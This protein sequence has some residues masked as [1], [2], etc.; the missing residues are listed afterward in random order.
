[1][2]NT[3]HQEKHFEDYIVSK[4]KAQGWLVGTTSGY[5]TERALYADDLIGWLQDTQPEK[6]DKLVQG[7]G[8]KARDVL[9]DRLA[10]VMED[11]GIMD[12]L[13]NGF[14]IAGCGQIDI[15]EAAPEDKRN[16]DVL[17]RY[18][19][20]RLRVVPQLKYHPTR[21]LAIDL[22]LFINGIPVATIEIK[23][24]FTQSADLAV[25]Q[26]K[27]D[28]LPVDPKTKRREPLL[29]FKRGAVVH[30]A[31]SETEI[32]MTTKLDGENTF[33]LP[34]NQGNNGR[35]G[36][37]PRDDGEYRV[38]YFWEQIC[39]RDSWLR[40]FHSF[41]YVEKKDV[42]DLKGNWSKKETLI[43]P[44]YHQWAA[45]NAM[46]ADAKTN[47]AGMQ[48]LCE[49]SA[50]SGKTSTIAW[51]A[52]DL[53]KLRSDD[54]EAI[55]SSVVIVTD[56]TVLDGQLQDAV[57][58]IDHQFGVIAAIDR[59][60]SSE[61]KSK[62]LA[63][64]LLSN[65]PIIIVTIQTFPYALE[66][67]VTVD[68]LKGKNFAVIIDEA[69]AS[70]TGTVAAKLQAALAIGGQGGMGDLTIE[71]L[72]KKM[73]ESRA[74]A[75]NISHFAFTA[76]PKHSTMMLFGRPADP[77]KPASDD[78]KPQ[79]FHRYTMRQAIDE[80]F[81]RDVLEGYVPYQTA[82]N[83]AKKV[84]DDKRVT[85][86]KAKKKLAEWMALHPTNVVQ[87]VQFIVEHFARSVAHLLG[88]RAK[89]M[90][91]TSSRAA[92]I[93]YKKGFDAY[94]AKHPE[95]AG[96]RSLVAFSGSLTGKQV[97]HNDDP[98]LAKDTFVVDEAAE[99]TEISMNPEIA[100]QDL[101][102]AFK[103]PEYR[104]MIV[105]DKFQTGFDQPMLVAMYIDKKIANDVEIVQTLSRLNRIAPGKDQTFVIDF[106][107]DPKTVKA[108]FLKYDAGAQIDE[109]QDP[110]VVYE[111]KSAL[112]DQPIY[113]DDD[114]EAFKQA[115]FRSI[116]DFAKAQDPQ[117]KALYAAT[118]RPTNVFNNQMKMLRE[119]VEKWEGE[120]EKARKK[121]ADDAMKAADHQ[122]QDYAE[123]VKQLLQF[124]NG[125][126]RFCRTYAYVAQL[127]D[128]GDPE[129]ENFAAFAK[130]LQ[131]RLNGEPSENIDLK[132]LVLTGFDIKLKAEE[133][134]EDDKP[135]V[136]KPIG[137]GG[138]TVTV[139]EVGYLKEI[140][141]RLNRLFGE[142]T[143]LS[144]QVALV[145]HVVDI[146]RENDTVV[147]QVMNNPREQ[148]LKGN[149][150][151]A[152][153]Q[154]VVR[155]FSSHRT[156][157]EIVLKSDRQAMDA[158]THLIYE[159]VKDGKKIDLTDLNV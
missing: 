75:Q 141:D 10:K 123:R 8:E 52:H 111:I 84:D 61:S 27:T 116:Q 133:H 46:I 18:A 104:V 14:Q 3:A 31:M 130:L 101:A 44:R 135:P 6:W 154:A 98:Q 115:R 124:K 22:V 55:F 156:L 143:P 145:N 91:V 100:G 126:G 38:A 43:F 9:M 13:R 105:A 132:G 157:A 11:R 24:D 1:M 129:L 117:H 45:V 65:T 87:K 92:A 15:S 110:N 67:I 90:V 63:K 74:R 5:D 62:Q 57:K 51:T 33:F 2:S 114:L 86:K 146:T 153:Q 59:Q 139:D 95:H 108:A 30:F 158:L 149:L 66:A 152:V 83:I 69:H 73:Q 128:F 94:I 40:I 20:N 136:L 144:D 159:L 107:N 49:H 72:L 50:G 89:A 7:N 76:T 54:G 48:Y 151:G 97:M 4:L 120:F 127:L 19:A 21:N 71:E 131:K 147:A 113:Q 25:E 93:R 112:D 12:V 109:I 118:E 96:I 60:K 78:N 80:V 28:R 41:V 53:I 79:A 121:G 148:A 85:G 42:V 99:F 36:N 125:L 23:T 34:F 102:T 70:Q 88:G 119:A 137:P 35:A 26:Y 150:P 142:T 140:I 39:Q 122:R 155:A 81:I 37:A 17:K 106:V 68:A 47:G 56:R 32:R 29:T 64:A 77:K 58:Q 82:F 16:K 138:K 134:I 103:R